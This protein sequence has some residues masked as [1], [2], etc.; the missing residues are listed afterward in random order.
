MDCSLKNVVEHNKIPKVQYA[1]TVF[2]CPVI[3]RQICMWC[4]LHI[5]DVAD[6]KTRNKTLDYSSPYYDSIP[7]LT[8]RDWNSIWVTCEKCRNNK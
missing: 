3:D 7:K 8:S 1:E 4:C 5:S 6:P 2:K